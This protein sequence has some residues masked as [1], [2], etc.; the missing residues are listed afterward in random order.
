[1]T[2]KV[3]HSADLHF[4]I[5]ADKLPEVV[6]TT[7]AL[8]VQARA[9]QPDVIV[10]AGD[11]VDE[12]DGRIRLDSDCAR[13]AIAFVQ[14]AANIAPV[15]IIRGTK[16]HDRESPYFFQHLRARNPIHVATSIEQMA[17]VRH[18]MD[19]HAYFYEWRPMNDQRLVDG[20]RTVAVFSLVP[21]L[22]KSQLLAHMDASIAGGN[23]IFRELVHDLFAGFGLVNET[24]QCPTF[25]VTHGMLTGAVFSSGQTAVGEDLEFGLSDLQA[26]KASAVLLGHVHKHQVFP[27]NVAYSGS[28]GRLNFGEQEDKGFLV[29]DCEGRAVPVM[30][31]IPLPARRFC[32]GAVEWDGSAATVLAEARRIAEDCSGADVR[33]RYTIPEE[34]RLSVDRSAL[35]L[36]FLGAGANRA[37]IE[38][39]VIPKQ[40]TRA[41]GISARHLLTEK[42]QQWGETVG[43]EIPA[44]VLLLASRIEGLSA[45]ELLAES[46]A[47]V[48]GEVAGGK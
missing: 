14:E 32:F 24:C 11:T 46:R 25:L 8:L 27:G 19:L 6:R 12:Y 31:F 20:E 22:D 26:A 35:E 48:E 29:W 42:V 18:D 9:E 36:L 13:A 39:N 5:S 7:D 23:V 21:S 37:K 47:L 28:P 3:L 45:D 4:S 44:D 38:M 40:R 34:E 17:L 43:E 33:F 30:R 15:V 41:A 2:L 1:M 16:S 10:L